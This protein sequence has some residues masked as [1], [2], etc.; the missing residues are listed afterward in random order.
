MQDTEYQIGIVR[1]ANKGSVSSFF[2]CV[3]ARS[4]SLFL[5]FFFTHFVIR[6]CILLLI[7][8]PLLNW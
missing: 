5:K 7:R 8:Y 1:T 6:K 2:Y 3:S 4:R